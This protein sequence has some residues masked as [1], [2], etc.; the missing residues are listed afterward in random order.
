MHRKSPVGLIIIGSLKL[1]SASLLAAV[2][3]GIFHMVSDI[4]LVLDHYVRML[5]LDPANKW[6]TETIAKITGIEPRQLRTIGAVTFFYALLYVIEGV[7]LLLA[8]HWAE[9]LTIIVTGSLL[10]V[11]IYEIIHRTTLIKIT[12]LIINVCI[13]VYLIRQLKRDKRMETLNL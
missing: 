5:H 9:Y 10:P 6:I 7:G 11:E 12:V 13:L 1:A 8:R 3:F 4:G 2:G